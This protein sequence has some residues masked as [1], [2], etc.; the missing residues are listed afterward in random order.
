MMNRRAGR[1]EFRGHAVPKA[2]MIVSH[3]PRDR[4]ES[5]LAIEPNNIAILNNLA[6]ALTQLRD[7]KAVE[8]AEKAYVEAPNDANVI[9][10]LGWALVQTGDAAKG[11]SLLR[12][13]SN[14]APTNAEIRLHLATAMIKTGDK[15]GARTEL[16]T[17]MKGDKESPVRA[18]ADKL[19]QGL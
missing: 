11:M 5:A 6:W 10:T 8:I 13:A 17:L 15:A 7:P 18:A 14:L 1:V 12:A 19:L 4:R 2:A 9:D 3:S 16:E